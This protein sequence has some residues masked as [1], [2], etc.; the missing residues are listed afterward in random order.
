MIYIDFTV[1]SLQI[2]FWSI[3]D[4]SNCENRTYINLT[5]IGQDTNSHTDG[6][7]PVSYLMS[8]SSLYEQYYCF[9]DKYSS[10]YGLQ[11]VAKYKDQL[12]KASMRRHGHL[13]VK[14][15][16]KSMRTAIASDH[17]QKT[18]SYLTLCEISSS[19]YCCAYDSHI[20]KSPV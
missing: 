18:R 10:S 14:H 5:R 11:H 16:G 1:N 2:Y 8:Y 9:I 13:Q 4:K 20:C 3:L 19:G 6:A 17:F 15:Y 7:N 12:K